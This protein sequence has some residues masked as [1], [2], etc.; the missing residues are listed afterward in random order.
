M[1]MCIS[2]LEKKI[3]EYEK[4]AGSQINPRNSYSEEINMGGYHVKN[5]L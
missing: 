3:A 4:I 2:D 1:H 5:S